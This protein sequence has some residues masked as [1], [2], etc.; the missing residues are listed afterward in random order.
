MC[1]E[2]CLTAWCLKRSGEDLVWA[3]CRSGIVKARCRPLHVA[4]CASQFAESLPYQEPLLRTSS[5]AAEMHN[6]CRETAG[7]ASEWPITVVAI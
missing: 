7:T 2:R 3:S 4:V 1:R 5:T 6:V